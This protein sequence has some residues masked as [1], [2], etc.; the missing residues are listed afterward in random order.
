MSEFE[1]D[2]E[3]DSDSNSE[4]D[5]SNASL[6]SEKELSNDLLDNDPPNFELDLLESYTDLYI[7]SPPIK[8]LLHEHW[9]AFSIEYSHVH[10]LY[11][12]LFYKK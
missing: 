1:S 12:L 5:P 6:E 9:S 11:M 2:F 4:S 10:D 8:L 3:S 7:S